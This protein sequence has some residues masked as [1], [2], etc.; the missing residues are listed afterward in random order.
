MTKGLTNIFVFTTKPY[1]SSALMRCTCK[2]RLECQIGYSVCH[3]FYGQNT[4]IEI[5]SLQSSRTLSVV[6]NIS[7][8]ILHRKRINA[9]S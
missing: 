1:F 3:V 6:Y 4:L 8:K 2:T 7:E 5:Y 9:E